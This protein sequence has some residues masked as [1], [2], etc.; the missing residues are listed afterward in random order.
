MK[1]VRVRFAPSPT[2]DLHIGGARTALFNWLFARHHKGKFILRIEDTDTV[3]S[4]KEAVDVILNGLR[5]LGLDWD[6]GP[7]IGGM[8]GPYFQMQRMDIYRSYAARLLASNNA[9]YCYCSAEELEERRQEALRGGLAPRYDGRCRVISEERKKE[10]ENRGINPV[11]RFRMPEGGVTR[12]NDLVRGE[13]TFENALLDDFV[14]LKSSGVPTYNFA[15]VVDDITMEITHVIRGDDHISN[16]PRQILLYNAMLSPLPEFAHIPMIFGSDRTRL[17]KRHGA[18]AIT[19]YEKEGYL[20]EA[21]VNYLTL[22]GWSTS[23]SQQIFKMEELIEKFSLERCAKSAAIFDSQKLLWLNGEYIRAMDTGELAER[24]LPY[25][26]EAGVP[27]DDMERVKKAI[28]L[29]HDKIRLLKDIPDLIRFMLEEDIV[30]EE[31][32]VESVMKKEGAA[33][34]LGELKEELAALENF[35]A[36]PL[37][38][39]ARGYAKRKGLKTPQ[40]FHPLRVS[41]SGRTKGPSLFDM[42]AFLGRETVI[43][44]MENAARKY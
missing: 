25:L 5:W 22:L 38:A 11:M 9:Y 18:T 40:V 13:V 3:R 24:A 21:M 7:D 36:A 34:I 39:L 1:Q 16:T 2:G 20:N 26:K 10:Y 35:A 4:T 37:E 19:Q 28:G 30:Y 6:E 8:F 42:L 27:L 41:V 12:I 43:R 29:E 33:K 44:R 23:E 15:V 31:D 14:I 17:S 32:A